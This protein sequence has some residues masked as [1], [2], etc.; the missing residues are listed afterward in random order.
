M[1]SRETQPRQ[2]YHENCEAG[3]NKQ[4]NLELYASYV[5]SSMAFYFDRDDVALPGFH[6]FFKKASHEERE[7]A[8]KFMK[9]QNMRGGRIVLQDVQKPERDEWGTGLEAMQCALAL[10]KRVN[11]SLLDLH[12]LADGHEDGQLTDFLEGEFLKEQVEAIK[13]LSDHVTQLKRV[14]PGLGEFMY[15]KELDS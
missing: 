2:N 14:G 9:Y 8:E 12:K 4:I 10:E 5:Y 3:I 6:K 15:D 11:Q 13:E 7:H 1:A